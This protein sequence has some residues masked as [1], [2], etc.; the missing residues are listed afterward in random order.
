MKA[1]NKEII[2]GREALQMLAQKSLPVLVSLQVARLGLAFSGPFMLFEEVRNRLI[3]KYG[4]VQES[5]ET[6]VVFPGDP[7]GREV[8]PDYQKFVEELTQLTEVENEIDIE[9]VKLPTQVDGHPLL[10][11][12]SIL[13][14]L[15]NFIE[16][17]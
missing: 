14:A 3:N 12:P 16:V 7:L 8:S 17:E 13:M 2:E 5:G 1:K 9:K 10:I 15:S 6:T 4:V 11:E